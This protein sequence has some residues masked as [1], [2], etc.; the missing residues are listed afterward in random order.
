MCV[1]CQSRDRIATGAAAAM[2][3]GLS[4]V[5]LRRDLPV[6]AGGLAAAGAV[7]LGRFLASLTSAALPPPTP[8]ARPKARR[9]SSPAAAPGK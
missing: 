8:R 9:P 5:A 6:L 2:L 7:A 3:I 4:L 1:P